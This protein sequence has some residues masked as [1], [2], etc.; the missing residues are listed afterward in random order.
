MRSSLNFALPGL[1]ITRGH[2]LTREV[3]GKKHYRCNPVGPQG[4]YSEVD[5]P[6]KKSPLLPLSEPEKLPSDRKPPEEEGRRR[7]ATAIEFRL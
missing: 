5:I 6:Y 1:H 2:K 3:L 4:P 7:Q